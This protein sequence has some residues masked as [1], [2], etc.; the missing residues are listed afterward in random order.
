LLKKKLTLTYKPN[1]ERFNWDV[2]MAQNCGKDAITSTVKA[3][4]SF[5][6]LSITRTFFIYA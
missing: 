4:I 2:G 6:F 5:S 3:A 1:H